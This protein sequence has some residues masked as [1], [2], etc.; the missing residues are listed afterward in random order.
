[1]SNIK[2]N[3]TIPS[4]NEKTICPRRHFNVQGTI[5]GNIPK[6]SKFKVELFDENNNLVRYAYSNRINNPNTFYGHPD[7]IKYQESEDPKYKKL[8]EFGFPELIVDDINNPYDSL[9]NANI[10]CYFTESI[11]KALIV[12]ASDVD[13]GAIFAD[14]INYLDENGKPYNYLQE[15]NYLIVCSLFD[16]IDNVLA[17]V[18]TSITIAPKDNLLL[19]RFNPKAHKENM[20]RWSKENNLTIINDTIPGYLESYTGNWYYHL[21]LLKMYRSN[22]ITTYYSGKVHMFIYCID[23]SS[24]SYATE[25]AY[26]QSKNALNEKDRINYYYYD[27]GE[28]LVGNK[29]GIIKQFDD[30][31]YIKICRVDIVNDLARENIF[32]LNEESMINTITDLDDIHINANRIAISGVIKPVQLNPKEFILKSDNTYEIKNKIC[33][34]KYTIL[35]KIIERKIGYQRIIDGI[36]QEPSVFEFYNV[37]EIDEN[38]KG[39]TLDISI[40]C[41]DEYDNKIGNANNL[42][43]KI[44]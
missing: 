39:K 28:A 33:K 35:D 3:I 34:L 17:S 6:N 2:I 14:G 30:D 41:F 24:T 42:K 26:L 36:I 37:F 13:H 20:C 38:Y 44:G 19:C 9:R 11:F 43:I 1:M 23:E 31:D 7:L 10:K 16:E 32:N 5:E 18:E 21:G 40:E 15:G 25:L 22:D 29:K 8:K 27:I 4:I 12:S